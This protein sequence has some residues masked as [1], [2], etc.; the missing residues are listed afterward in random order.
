M[1]MEEKANAMIRGK[2]TDF[3]RTFVP[4]NPESYDSDE[5]EGQRSTSIQRNSNISLPGAYRVSSE[6]QQSAPQTDVASLASAVSS[7]EDSHDK[8]IVVPRASLVHESTEHEGDVENPASLVP[9]EA[10]PPV[11]EVVES[12]G[13]AQDPSSS[14]VVK[15]TKK[16]R[17]FRFCVLLTLLLIAAALIAI[18][19]QV[20]RNVR[21][22]DAL[23]PRP[24]PPPK[25][26]RPPKDGDY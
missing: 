23:P 2:S 25:K 26:Q 3:D 7:Q 22:D 9:G 24:P 5:N 12:D 1:V 19:V 15:P 4:R 6:W 8:T 18:L 10:V 20:T 21:D 14:S 13:A 16:Q 11:A 17:V